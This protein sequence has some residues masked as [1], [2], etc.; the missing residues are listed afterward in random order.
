MTPHKHQPGNQLRPD[1]GI[2]NYEIGEVEVMAAVGNNGADKLIATWWQNFK[3]GTDGARSVRVVQFD[4]TG[5][6]PIR[7]TDYQDC[8]PISFKI[9]NLKGDS[10]DIAKFTLALQPNDRVYF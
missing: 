5:Q 7:T 6:I 8:L 2:G 3:N 10:S 4:A 9:D 1:H